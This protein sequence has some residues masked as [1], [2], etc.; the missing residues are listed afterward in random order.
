VAD[1][2]GDHREQHDREQGAVADEAMIAGQAAKN[3][4]TMPRRSST[5]PVVDSGPEN[6]R[7]NA[8]ATPRT[9]MPI[10][11]G[12]RM[13]FSTTIAIGATGTWRS[14][15]NRRPTSFTDSG[16]NTI[17]TSASVASRPT[18]YDTLPPA[19][20]CL[21]GSTGGTGETASRMS[22][23]SISRPEREQQRDRRRH[24]RHDDVHRQQRPHE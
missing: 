19:L 18:A 20:A 9:T 7:A 15:P 1:D 24:D 14:W 11:S 23:I 12:I 22:A 10:T 3:T 21:F 8:G 17:E 2:E 4:G 16:T 13:D 6:R 5:V